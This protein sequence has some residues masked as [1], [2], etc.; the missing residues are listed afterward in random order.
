MI[1]R[2]NHRNYG[3]PVGEGQDGNL[4]AGEKFFNDNLVAALAEHLVLHHGLNG[5]LCLLPG[6]GNN[7]TLTQ[8][9]AISLD[10]RGHRSRI[11]IP[12]GGFHIRKHF[13]LGGGDMV[14]LHQILG[15]NLAAFNDGGVCSGA[16]AGNSLHLQGI[17]CPQNQRIIRGDHSIIHPMRNCKLYNLGNVLGTDIHADCV[18]SNAAVAGKGENLRNLGIFLQF[19]NDGVLPAAAAH[20]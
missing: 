9:Q 7:N 13:I 15:K 3:F 12:K 11:Q 4:R 5:L 6:L 17:H 19:F 1:H 8:S 18:G 10:N 20:N 16:E 14:F 2:G